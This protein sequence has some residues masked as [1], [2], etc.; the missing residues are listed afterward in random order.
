[1]STGV[2]C[3][4]LLAAALH[5]GW[6]AIVKGAG[7]KRLSTVVV[8]SSS[9]A[10]SAVALPF[11]P[12]PDAASWPFIA[13]SVLL[14]QA[15]FALVMAAYHTGDMSRAYPLMRGTAPMLVAAASLPLFGEALASAGW[16]GVALITGGVFALLLPMRAGAG[17][18]ATI[19]ALLNAV[20]IAAYTLV[21]GMGARLSGAPTAYTLWVFLLAGAIFAAG[22]AV[23]NRG[24][25]P[26]LA[27]HLRLGLAGG[28]GSV[29]SYATVLWAMTLA[30]V[31]MVAALRETSILFATL[32]AA[33]ILKE[34]VG[35]A[36][37][38][39]AG[40][41]AAGAVVLRLA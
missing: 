32:L 17:H 5:A 14:H 24:A 37:A 6:Y 16:G 8:A 34:P 39:A 27:G 12:Q 28:L 26:P 2:F 29:L 31:A 15:Y 35:P 36:R 10:L 30:P 21:D 7:D 25:R 38:L 40:T 9:G 33:T 19:Y 11:F 13:G 23:R 22:W 3:L 18:R 1:M 41:I 20:V 4:V